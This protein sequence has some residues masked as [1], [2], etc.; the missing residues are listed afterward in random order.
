MTLYLRSESR[1]AMDAALT[2][3]GIPVEGCDWCA[4][5]HIGPI[6]RMEGD[7]AVTVDSR[8]H[9]NLLFHRLTPDDAMLSALPT[10][11]EPSSPARMFA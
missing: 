7:D 8:H 1:A 11:P 9:T 2:A 10:I 4:V 5:D 3:A 6:I